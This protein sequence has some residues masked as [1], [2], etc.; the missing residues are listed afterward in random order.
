[1]T[2]NNHQNKHQNHS[3]K[4]LAEA[5][6]VISFLQDNLQSQ[7]E[8]IQTIEQQY[9]ILQQQ[10]TALL[11]NRY[12]K[13]S[14]QLPE[15]F[16]QLNLFADPESP[17]K[18]AE[19]ESTEESI[20]I[21][22]ITYTRKKRS[23]HRNIPDDLTR[24]RIEHVLKDLN[25]PCGCGNQLHKIGEVITEQLEIVPAKIYVKQHARFKYAGC[26]HQNKVVTAPMPN[27][28]IDKGFAGPGLL[29]D[30]LVKKYD[31]HLPLY[32]QSEILAR[33][34][35]EISKQTLGDWVM[36]CADLLNP[37]V[38]VMKPDLLSSPKIHTDDTVVP[39]LEEKKPKTKKDLSEKEMSITN[40]E[41]GKTKKGRLWVYAGQGPPCIIYD[42]SPDRKQI[43]A[44][45]FLKDYEGYLQADA[46][47]GYDKVYAEYKIIEVGCM[48][49]ARRKF[50]DIIQV[51]NRITKTKNKAGVAVTALSYIGKLYRIE[52]QAKHLDPIA[53]QALRKRKAKPI[54]KDYKKYLLEHGLKALPKS[55]LGQAV[56]YTLK[57]WVALTRYLGN[58][59][60]DIGRVENWRVSFRILVKYLS[61]YVKKFRSPSFLN[62]VSS[63]RSS[64]RTCATNAS[65]FRTKHHA[66]ALGTSA[67]T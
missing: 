60:L 33:H 58:G 46:Y 40:K 16:N 37:I 18:S 66:F 7:Q 57:N 14:E 48:A 20:K 53:K 4:T 56:R 51:N 21:E 19:E 28:P 1:M 3:P 29:A 54:L 26:K 42:Y 9:E 63:P 59:I 45:E 11:R 22:S 25:C 67:I 30:V 31:D 43:W 62:Y 13:K 6:Q 64:N 32:R 2:A 49:H 23:G 35:I 27:Q 50:F 12:G 10:L 52:N 17:K 61:V 15:G 36:Q 65:G 5:N 34:G 47:T 55:P 24:I 41:R 44:E 8:K 39:I 38:K